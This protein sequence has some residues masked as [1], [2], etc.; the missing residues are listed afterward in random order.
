MRWTPSSARAIEYRP[1]PQPNIENAL[2]LELECMFKAQGET[3]V[4]VPAEAAIDR[5]D[6]IV[7]DPFW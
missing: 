5:A 4:N 2:G 7:G 1:G 6:E 3:L